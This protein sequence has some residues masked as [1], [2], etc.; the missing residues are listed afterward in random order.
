MAGHQYDRV[1]YHPSA[2]TWSA[3]SKLRLPAPR[4]YAA[5]A[6]IGERVYVIGGYEDSAELAH[7]NMWAYDSSTNEWTTLAPLPTPLMFHEAVVVDGLIWVFGGSD[8]YGDMNLGLYVYDPEVDS[9]ST[10]EGPPTPRIDGAGIALDGLIY[11]FGGLS[12][13]TGEYLTAAEVY[14]P[15]A[16]SWSTVPDLPVPLARMGV[17]EYEGVVYLVGGT[18]TDWWG[19]GTKTV[20]RFDPIAETWKDLSPTILAL[21]A[22]EAVHSS[23]S[24]AMEGQGIFSMNGMSAGESSARM[25]LLADP[26]LTI[27]ITSLDPTH[28]PVVGGNEV[29]ILGTN[30]YDVTGVD[31]GSVPATGFVVASPGRIVATAPA[32]VAGVVQVQV[33]SGGGST[34][35]TAADDYTYGDAAGITG[36]SVHSGP[37]AGGTTVV[38]TGTGFNGVIGADAVTFGGVPAASYTRDSETQ[39]T[40]V[41]PP[42]AAGPVQVQVTTAVGAT[43]DVAADDFLYFIAYNVLRGVD[44][45]DTALKISKAMFPGALPLGSGLVLAPGDTFQE[46]LCGAP[47]AS[48]YGGPV[49]LTPRTVLTTAMKAE[50]LRLHPQTVICIGLSDTMKNKVQTA[51]GATGTA[52]AIRGTSVYDMSYKVA[53]ALETKVGDLSGATAII[54]RGD[55]FAD[56]IG[57][58]PLACAQTWPVILTGS[59]LSL[60]FSATKALSELGIVAAIKVGTYATLPVGVT[61]LA[62]LSGADRYA[63]N[64]NVAEWA[65]AHAGLSFFHLGIVTGDKFPDALAAGPYLA[66]QRGIVL[67]SPLLGPLPGV[68]AAEISGNAGEVRR[69]SFMGMIEPVIG[70]VKALLP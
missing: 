6:T 34:A 5:S 39:I 55:V 54:A 30:F 52:I 45:Y 33:V 20:L 8:D 28:G 61:G 46:A 51:L 1:R 26:A 58:S 56:A 17:A 11:Y 31:F 60:T 66:Q 41:S 38:I 49:L 50:I 53:K 21:P 23:P 69:V 4:V 12:T 14:D 9:W 37:A 57:V 15:I 68:V 16:A 3:T 10:L 40:A 36:L 13:E 25:E 67:L 32:G 43:P 7:D 65:V 29:A 24:V 62:N 44:R 42:H 35:D 47:L 59:G 2:D 63:T 64:V 70:Q 18:R 22:E 27:S 19:G 48:A